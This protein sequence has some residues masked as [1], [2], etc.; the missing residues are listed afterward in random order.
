M[1]RPIQ[2]LQGG[3]ARIGAGAF[4]VQSD[5]ELE[6]LADSF[7]QMSGQLREL[8]AT[9]EQRVDEAPAASAP[10]AQTRRCRA[11]RAA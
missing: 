7:N 5:D 4:D 3:A 10:C 11:R 8:Y 9:L 6:D 1:V 2:A